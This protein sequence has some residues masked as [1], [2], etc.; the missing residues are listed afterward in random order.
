MDDGHLEVFTG[1]RVQRND[2][3]GPYKGGVRYHPNVTLDEV[4]A[5]A[6][7][8]TW[9]CAVHDLPYGGEGGVVCDPKKMSVGELERLTR[10][11]TFMIADFIGPFRNVPDPDLY[12][13]SRE[14]AWM[15]D[16]YSQLKGYPSLR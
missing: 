8:M 6:M 12:T 11:Y 10:R 15:M 4:K 16:T 1:C 14:M 3:R 9:K 7:L 13:G 2:A 5:S